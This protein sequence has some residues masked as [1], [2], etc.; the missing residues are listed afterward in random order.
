[1]DLN[2]FLC[3]QKS[4]IYVKCVFSLL[5]VALKFF[6]SCEYREHM[7]LQCVAKG[8]TRLELLKNAVT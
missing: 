8:N 2:L 4:V 6:L 7:D 3:V 5:T 1:M